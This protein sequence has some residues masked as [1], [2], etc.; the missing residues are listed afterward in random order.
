[1]K[2]IFN[3]HLYH[4]LAVMFLSG[5]FFVAFAYLSYS[6]FHLSMANIDFLREHGAAAIM[7][8]ALLQLLEIFVRGCLAL[9][10]YLAF[11][12]CETELT[13]RY[14]RWAEK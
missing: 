7:E 4:W 8:G 12:V 9:S 14:H 13:K 1:M 10:C 2:R 11:K 5:V 3:L 6:L